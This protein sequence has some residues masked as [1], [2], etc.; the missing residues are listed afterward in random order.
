MSYLELGFSHPEERGGR[1]LIFAFHLASAY[2]PRYR[3]S[4]CTLG[5]QQISVE[6][7]WNSFLEF[8][9]CFD[10]KR[11]L[12]IRQKSKEK[13]SGW[14]RRDSHTLM[15]GPRTSA[16]VCLAPWPQWA[17][18]PWQVPTAVFL[19]LPPCSAPTSSQLPPGHWRQEDVDLLVLSVSQLSSTLSLIFNFTRTHGAVMNCCVSAAIRLGKGGFCLWDPPETLWWLF[20]F[21]IS[22]SQGKL[23]K[24]HL[25]IYAM[26]SFTPDTFPEAGSMHCPFDRRPCSLSSFGHNTNCTDLIKRTP[27]RFFFSL[28][29]FL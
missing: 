24:I 14:S 2:L 7:K 25:L 17:K 12:Y 1:L 11:T 6:W 5:A 3:S 22:D 27:V 15:E 19:T 28:L 21:F 8:L 16:N 26:N 9:S 29:C 10:V 18:L 13:W 23:F 20:L 4:D